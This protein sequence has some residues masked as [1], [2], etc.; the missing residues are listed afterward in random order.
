MIVIMFEQN[1]TSSQAS[2]LNKAVIEADDYSPINEKE[3]AIHIFDCTINDSPKRKETAIV[4]EEVDPE[5]PNCLTN[6]RL[7]DYFFIAGIP[8]KNQKILELQ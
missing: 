6:E 5:D 3:L 8:K 4:L 2:P 1:A 7:F